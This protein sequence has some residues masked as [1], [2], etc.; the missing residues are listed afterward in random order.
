MINLTSIDVRYWDFNMNSMLKIDPNRLQILHELTRRRIYVGELIYDPKRDV[1]ELRYDKNYVNSKKAIPLGPEL[2]LFKMVHVSKKGQLFPVFLDRIPEKSN[3][4]YKDYCLS[5]GI[6]QKES[7]PII[8]LGSIGAR[9]PSSFVFEHVYKAD[10]SADD[11]IKIRKDLGVSQ[12]D[13]A[14]AFGI[15]EITLQRIES[16]VGSDQNTIKLLQIY[17][18]FP[19][20]AFWQLRQTGVRVHSSVLAKLIQYFKSNTNYAK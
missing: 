13:L 7:N 18:S 10:F 12:Y 6:S 4:A 5:Q 16:G 15:K 2:D 8:L 14:T 11:I 19:D 17:F 9:G 3:P 1:Y 20:V